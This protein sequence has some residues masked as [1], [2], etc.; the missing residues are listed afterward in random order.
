MQ[1]KLETAVEIA[2]KRIDMLE[3]HRKEL[4]KKSTA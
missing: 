1:I 3:A 2:G 4:Y